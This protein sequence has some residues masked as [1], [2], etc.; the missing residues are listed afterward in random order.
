ML[1]S[2]G[3]FENISSGF[4]KL[5]GSKSGFISPKLSI[6]LSL[7]FC[8]CSRMNKKGAL[9]FPKDSAINSRAIKAMVASLSSTSNLVILDSKF[10]LLI[11]RL[12][13]LGRTTPK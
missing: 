12:L 4:E 13:L 7:L 3:I 10:N 9:N 11:A 6:K 1:F 8:I 2:S 5:V